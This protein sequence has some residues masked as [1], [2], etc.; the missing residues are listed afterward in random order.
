[1]S[2]PI[3]IACVEFINTRPLIEGLESNADVR[4]IRAV[5]SKLLGI[6]K[7]GEADIALLPCIDYH[8]IPGLRIIP[9]GGIG[10]FGPTLTV[11]LF[12]HVPAT[13]IRSVACDS[14]SHTSVA[15]AKILFA[16]LYK[17]NPRFIEMKQAT[18]APDEARLLIGDKVICEEPLGF[19]H[20]IDLGEAWKEL[21]GLPFVF[22][23]WC[24]MPGVELGDL[25]HEL[26]RA[27]KRGIANVRQIVERYAVP[28]GWPAGIAI[29]YLTLYLKYEIGPL[30]LEA[31]RTFHHC[32]EELGLLAG[33]KRALDVVRTEPVARLWDND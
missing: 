7:A 28:R 12:S 29:Q 14:D 17:A 20:Q 27:R 19:Q 24:A 26:E 3:R 30:Q 18:S 23:I 13:Q 8:A 22:A 2:H 25:P 10:C 1:M 31:I 9:A 5:P 16:K 6:L 11:R 32:A 15:L 4:L 33:P 21:T